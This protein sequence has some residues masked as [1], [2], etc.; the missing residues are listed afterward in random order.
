MASAPD[1]EI[2]FGTALKF[3]V[4][5][6]HPCIQIAEPRMNGGTVVLVRITTWAESK[7]DQECILDQSDW[8]ELDRRS[9]VAYSKAHEG[10][11]DIQQLQAAIR[12]GKFQILKT[13]PIDLVRRIV[14]SATGS[15]MKP[16]IKRLLPSV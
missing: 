5:P 7:H 10:T 6:Y 2:T 3:C 4:E 8:D 1:I 14:R 12:A 11:G 16:K 9:T 13:P 15:S